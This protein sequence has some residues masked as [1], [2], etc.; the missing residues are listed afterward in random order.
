MFI[1]ET[2][3]LTHTFPNGVIAVKEIN[4]RIS[5]GEFVVLAGA[6]GSGKTVFLRHLN[7]LI[8]PTKG[9]T[10]LNGKNI[11]KNLTET[12]KQIG[13]IFQDPDSQ[14]LGQTVAEDVSFGPEN[15]KLSWNE[16]NTRVK[17]ALEIAGLNKFSKRDPFT[18]SG[19]QKR[20]L[21][22]AGVL[23]MKPK[24]IMFDEPFIGLDYP[25]VVQVLKQIIELN[26]DGHTIILVT[27]DLEK[28]LAH[29]HRLIIMS[30]GK[31][32]QDGKPED[33]IDHTEKYQVK[34]PSYEKGGINKL[35]WLK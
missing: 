30:K 25:G 12:R 22:I 21:A 19:G 32:V 6:N 4:L 9:K 16:I 2:I 17:D 8:L 24:V 35:T 3:N 28:V 11:L 34:M 31:I 18:L 33:I 23:A 1:L 15:L 5:P 13:L 20:K 26:V 27:H 7:G 29:A 10:L 14:I